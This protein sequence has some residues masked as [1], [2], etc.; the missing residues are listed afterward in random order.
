MALI[1]YTY[2]KG[3]INIPSA[4]DGVSTVTGNTLDDTYLATYEEDYLR[5][6]LGYDLYKAFTDGLNEIPI[7]TKWTDLRDGKEYTI[8]S[9]TY[10]WDGFV[11]SR[12]VSPIANYIFCIYAA[13]ASVS[14][15]G[16]GALIQNTQN[17][18]NVSPSQ[19]IAQAWADMKKMNVSLYHY[20]DN[21]Q[22]TYTEYADSL[23]GDFGYRNHLGL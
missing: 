2:F 6:A 12:K 7:A 17:A 11:N 13:D 9:N 8:N 23:I 18:V 21:H 10:K 4:K 5:I 19:L 16:T 3:K 15:Q 14:M 22:S 20:L 1:D